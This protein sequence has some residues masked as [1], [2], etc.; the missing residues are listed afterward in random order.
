MEI[1]S[2]AQR[3]VTETRNLIWLV[4]DGNDYDNHNAQ[5]YCSSWWW[6]GIH[7]SRRKSTTQTLPSTSFPSRS[8]WMALLLGQAIALLA[9]S[10]NAASFTLVS[11]FH[12]QTQMFQ[13]FFL[14]ILL[15]MF[16]FRRKP[17]ASGSCISQQQ[18]ES[19][20]IPG[21]SRIKLRAPW[22][23]YLLC[24][25]LD[26]FPN[27]LALLS[28]KYTSL[29]SAVILGSLTIPSTMCFAKLILKKSFR[30][31]QYLGVCLCVIGGVMIVFADSSVTETSVASSNDGG[32]NDNT[33]FDEPPTSTSLLDTF[34]GDAMAIGAAVCYGLGDTVAE[35]FCKHVE[36]NEYLGMLGLYGMLFTGISF[37][38]L[39]HD[40]LRSIALQ[41]TY[42][43]WCIAG[44]FMWYVASVYFYY[45]TVAV[46]LISSD[47][48][49]LNMSMQAA[50]LWTII[51]SIAVDHQATPSNLFFAAAALIVGGVFV[52]EVAQRPYDGAL[53]HLPTVVAQDESMDEEIVEGDD[54]DEF[55]E[56]E[57]VNIQE[58]R[59][60]TDSVDIRLPAIQLA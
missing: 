28:L 16:L 31:A 45:T 17:I 25:I 32:N 40:A 11:R 42:T 9:A 48:T 53:E 47:A 46:F 23:I 58:Q 33:T 37:P 13:M 49:L 7:R 51:F 10:M 18:S 6:S 3:V 54:D 43:Q 30:P 19:Y 4:M 55:G 41:S 29:T 34:W 5:Q 26:V 8:H 36:R 56:V 21:C 1:R 24:S 57:E 59:R 2:F 38:M 22:W 44:I 12:V 20:A 14:Y 39:E 27:F 35:Y 50:T 60:K 52:Y 15:S